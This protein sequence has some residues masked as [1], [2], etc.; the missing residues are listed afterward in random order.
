MHAP[1]SHRRTRSSCILPAPRRV[2]VVYQQAEGLL[3]VLGF[4]AT[5]D[6]P[7]QLSLTIP[8]GAATD[9]GGATNA[10][11]TA[12]LAYQPA[13]SSPG[14]LGDVGSAAFG[15][16]MVLSF[17]TGLMGG[18]LGIGALG[19]AG[20]AQTFYYS[21]ALPLTN[22]PEVGLGGRARCLAVPAAWL[23]QRR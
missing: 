6:Q 5:R 8:A 18:G 4:V 22:M 10:G 21:G 7:A 3:Y 16:T 19:F 15:G 17:A 20:Y 11:A 9:A 12:T 1:P 14:W 2:D 13:A 23:W